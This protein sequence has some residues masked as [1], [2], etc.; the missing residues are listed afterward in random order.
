MFH[1]FLKS[2]TGFYESMA[3]FCILGGLKHFVSTSV[4]SVKL[5][6]NVEYFF[7]PCGKVRCELFKT[8]WKKFD[9][10]LGYLTSSDALF[11][12]IYSI[13]PLLGRL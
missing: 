3:S 7:M 6:T 8:W 4:N 1:C 9:K 5:L 13:G 10:Y 11:S 12:S 2:F